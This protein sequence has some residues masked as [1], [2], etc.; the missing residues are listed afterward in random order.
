M[1]GDQNPVPG[2][3]EL[4]YWWPGWNSTNSVTKF[5]I[6]VNGPLHDPNPGKRL[7]EPTPGRRVGE[8]PHQRLDRSDTETAWLIPRPAIYVSEELS[9][10]SLAIS[11]LSPRPEITMHPDL[12]ARLGL[13]D[14]DVVRL[15]LGG[16]AIS[17]PCKLDPSVA[18]NVAAV[19]ANIDATIGLTAPVTLRK[20]PGGLEIGRDE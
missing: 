8:L 15:D 10:L 17:L 1:E 16:R 18:P 13:G 9:A 11:E 2:P 14:G 7:I 6:E 4:R 12:A 20:G 3:L 19:P 5:Q